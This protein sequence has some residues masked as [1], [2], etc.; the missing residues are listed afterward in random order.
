[1]EGTA[2][3]HAPFF[4]LTNE[5]LRLAAG[6]RCKTHRGKTRG[7]KGDGQGAQTPQPSNHMT[8][9]PFRKSTPH[10]SYGRCRQRRG[11]KFFSCEIDR[12][13]RPE[14]A[15]DD[16]SCSYPRIGYRHFIDPSRACLALKVVDHPFGAYAAITRVALPGA[17]VASPNRSRSCRA[18]LCCLRWCVRRLS[19]CPHE[20]GEFTR[21]GHTHLVPVHSTGVELCEALRQA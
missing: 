16:E 20:A 14:R 13:M 10:G 15:S 1:M 2:P 4:F 6:C 12:V 7:T 11:F 5:P 17:W 21:H 9:Q 3:P 18:S 19:N 8:C